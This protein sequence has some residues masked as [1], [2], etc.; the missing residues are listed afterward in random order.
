MV[1]R[2]QWAW[3]AAILFSCLLTR[4]ADNDSPARKQYEQIVRER[5]A[6]EKKWR[7]GHN[8]AKTDAERSKLKYPQPQQYAA[9]LLAVAK[10]HPRDPAAIDAL[11]WIGQNCRDGDEL[12]E[13]LRLLLAEH[14]KAE[15]LTNVVS[16]LQYANS[17][18][19]EPFL[20]GVAEKS[21]SDAVKGRALLTLGRILKDRA[22]YVD[23]LKT[24]TSAQDPM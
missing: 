9:R 12:D 16:R 4:S 19:V 23:V 1:L 22:E 24:N 18:E 17:N 15:A 7:E 21:P 13:A 14:A 5:E 6:A 11:V 8:E 10:E 20:R 2:G 3:V